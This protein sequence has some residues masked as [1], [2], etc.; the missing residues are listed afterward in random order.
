LGLRP[1]G[2]PPICV[3]RKFSTVDYE[4]MVM[5]VQHIIDKKRSTKSIRFDIDSNQEDIQKNLDI[6]MDVNCMK[7]LIGGD[8]KKAKRKV[9]NYIWDNDVLMF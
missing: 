1:F 5:E 4:Q 8:I 6:W 3:R 9:M 7:L 2:L